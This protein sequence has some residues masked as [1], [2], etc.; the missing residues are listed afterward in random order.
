MPFSETN[1]CSKKQW[2]SIY[3][4][5]FKKT[6]EEAGLGYECRRSSATRGNI[7]KGIIADL[8][9]SYVVLADLTD[10]NPNVFYELGI[11]HAL[12]P[13]TI[14]IA[15]DRKYIPFDLRGY[16]N[17]IYDW[18][19]PNGRLKFR[20][21]VIEILKDIDKDSDRS[22]NPVSDFLV[23]TSTPELQPATGSKA[24]E[25]RIS[26]VGPDASKLKISD[27]VKRMAEENRQ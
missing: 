26:I 19:T 24:D 4:N 17:H 25:D 5:L 3:N 12:R 2:T 1:S 13:R 6:I 11:R 22:D 15:Q 20:R 7:I 14:L 27:I 23:R 8:D 21:K 18:R 9:S 16:A 10:Q